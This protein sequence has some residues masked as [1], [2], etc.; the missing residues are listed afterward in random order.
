MMANILPYARII[1][2]ACF[3]GTIE[4]PVVVT[5]LRLDVFKLKPTSIPSHS[6]RADIRE[7]V[8]AFVQS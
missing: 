8:P 2:H 3:V 7:I 4:V 5:S 6:Y 1:H